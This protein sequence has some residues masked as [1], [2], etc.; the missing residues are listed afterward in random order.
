MKLVIKNIS[1]IILLVIPLVIHFW[2][3]NKNPYIPLADSATNFA[4]TQ[5]IYQDFTTHGP[6]KG[7]HSFF[8]ERSWRA[9]AMTS[10]GVPFLAMTGGDV[11]YARFLCN[12]FFFGIFIFYLFLLFRIKLGSL[13]AAVATLSITMI[14]WVFLNIFGYMSE[15]FFLPLATATLYHLLQCN[16]F[17]ERWHSKLCFFWLTLSLLVRPF[18]GLLFLGSV[19]LSCL[20]YAYKRRKLSFVDLSL[21]FLVPLTFLLVLFTQYFEKAMNIVL[22]PWV[23]VFLFIGFI[24]YLG[25]TRHHYLHMA[26]QR[27]I[28]IT[29]L[30][31]LI[32]YFPYA[33]ELF[34]WLLHCTVSENILKFDLNKDQSLGHFLSELYFHLGNYRFWILGFVQLL[35][36]TPSF[37]RKGRLPIRRYQTLCLAGFILSVLSVAQLTLN[38]DLRYFYL[39][40]IALNVCFYFGLFE[41]KLSNWV[42]IL[43]C[44]G[45]LFVELERISWFFSGRTHI[46]SIVSERFIN[47]GRINDVFAS[48]IENTLYRK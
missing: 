7:L 38:R 48:S 40:I 10:M 32:W 43:I 35:I 24:L 6:G 44:I 5:K 4:V 18:V 21:S 26:L 45:I 16:L 1:I 11:A 23:M 22:G 34:N 14:P 30:V 33:S 46:N 36:I 20:V 29:C 9:I 12:S 28:L 47:E 8:H 25:K 27:S 39:P 42:K 37:L 17:Q 13:S 41:T 15:I 2:C 31:Q 3:F 19:I